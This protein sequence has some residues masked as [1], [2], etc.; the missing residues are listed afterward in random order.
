MNPLTIRELQSNEETCGRYAAPLINYPPGPARHALLAAESR[1]KYPCPVCGFVK[2]TVS[3]FTDPLH[4]DARAYCVCE[5][6]GH[7]EPA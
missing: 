7:C 2:R 4:P 1:I 6:C 5:F 3:L